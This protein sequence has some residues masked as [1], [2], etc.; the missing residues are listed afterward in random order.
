MK[1]GDKT[2]DGTAWEAVAPVGVPVIAADCCCRLAPAWRDKDRRHVASTGPRGCVGLGGPIAQPASHSLRI[3]LP[4]VGPTRGLD[5]RHN[6]K[7]SAPKRT[8]RPSRSARG[9]L[10]AS[11]PYPPRSS[12]AGAFGRRREADQAKALAGAS[13]LR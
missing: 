6:E 7:S 12:A 10:S 5:H 9:L 2:C 13:Y 3:Q 8:E 1:V 11:S 4:S